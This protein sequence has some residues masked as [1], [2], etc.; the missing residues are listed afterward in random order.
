MCVSDGVV[1]S[2][3]VGTA[4]SGRKGSPNNSSLGVQVGSGRSVDRVLHL[5]GLANVEGVVEHLCLLRLRCRG[6]VHKVV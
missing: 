2:G 5:D 1:G 4:V 3:V 6:R